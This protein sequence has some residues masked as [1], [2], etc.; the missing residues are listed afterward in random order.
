MPVVRLRIDISGSLGESAWRDIH[1]F[2]KAQAAF[3]GPEFGASGPCEHAP[4]APHLR[5]EWWGA[6]ILVASDL[7]AQYAITH[8]LEQERVLDADAER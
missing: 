6:E 2:R 1:Q 3:F 5:G 7:L 4:G 8:Y